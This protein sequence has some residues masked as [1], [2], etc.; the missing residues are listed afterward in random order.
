M[1]T[2]SYL[3]RPVRSEAEL[4]DR[5]EVLPIAVAWR[6]II[7]RQAARDEDERLD[8]LVDLCTRLCDGDAV[9]GR[10]LASKAIWTPG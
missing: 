8:R 2:S 5:R 6:K 10:L 3:T 1:T 4:G 9:A 7:W